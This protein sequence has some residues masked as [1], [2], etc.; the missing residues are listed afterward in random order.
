MQRAEPGELARLVIIDGV[1][2]QVLLLRLVLGRPG[3]AARLGQAGA[4]EHH[5]R[6]ADAALGQRHLRLQQF[7]LQP[8]RPQLARVMNSSSDQARR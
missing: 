5:D 7:E 4:A 1:L 3:L 2:E 6:R 8:D